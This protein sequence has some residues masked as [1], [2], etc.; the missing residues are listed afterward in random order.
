VNVANIFLFHADKLPA[1]VLDGYVVIYID[2]IRIVGMGV[3]GVLVS[4]FLDLTCVGEPVGAIGVVGITMAGYSVHD[5]AHVYVRAS[6]LYVG[7][8]MNG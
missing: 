4:V 7:W 3:V 2:Q 8:R 5:L 6:V 1:G